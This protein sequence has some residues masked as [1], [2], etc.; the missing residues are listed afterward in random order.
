MGVRGVW[1]DSC[2]YRSRPRHSRGGERWSAV[3]R[4]GMR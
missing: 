4:S 1:A 3:R 2:I